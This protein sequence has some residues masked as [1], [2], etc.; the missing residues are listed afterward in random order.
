MFIKELEEEIK[1]IG[2]EKSRFFDYYL[3]ARVQINK[4]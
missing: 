2:Q 4:K 1:S 3:E